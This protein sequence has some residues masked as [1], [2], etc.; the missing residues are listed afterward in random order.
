MSRLKKLSAH[1]IVCAHK[2]CRGR[3]GAEA[4]KAL[5]RAVK[6]HDDLRGRVL[7]T[8]VKCLDQCG[9]GPVAVVYPDGVW[10]GSVD[11][12][13]AREIVAEHLVAGREAAGVKILRDMRDD[14]ARAGETPEA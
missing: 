8:K 3:G 14:K 6:E 9:R 10:Y 12:R 2:H 1:V 11:E 5:K 7:V 13:G 4:T